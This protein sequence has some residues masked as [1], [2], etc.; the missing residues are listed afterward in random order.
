V[1]KAS[2]RSGVV[3]VEQEGRVLLRLDHPNIIGG[4]EVIRVQGRMGV[5]MEFVD[6]PNLR[7]WVDDARPPLHK[8]IPVFHGVVRGLLA[9]HD[10]GFVHR[11]LKPENILV[12]VDL[13]IPTAKIGDFGLVITSGQRVDEVVGT[14]QYMA[15]EQSRPP[16]H[17]DPRADLF[18]LGCILY[19]MVCFRPALATH[20]AQGAFRL[21]AARG[22]P[23][24]ERVTPGLPMALVD[25]I[26]V[27]LE[28]D[29]AKRIGDCA[30]VLDAL[31]RPDLLQRLEYRP[32]RG[33]SRH[34]TTGWDAPV[35]SDA[36][37]TPSA[38]KERRM[39]ESP[40]TWL[41]LALPLVLAVFGLVVALMTAASLQ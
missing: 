25:L 12:A 4:R 23:R 20:D 36:V 5:A 1:V 16:V 21:A 10:S 27:L 40:A 39:T 13:D 35:S 15:P 28:P 38:A 34:E 30:A 2:D 26:D 37:A 29:P 32:P 8:V 31:D 41:A 24:P 19:E 6:G 7:R 33:V 22:Y 9:V 3:A 18:A 11:D 17:A 14:P